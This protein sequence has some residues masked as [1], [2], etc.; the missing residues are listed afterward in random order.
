Q[1]TQI[2][3]NEGNIL[4]AMSAIES[5]QFSSISAAAKAFNILKATL[6]RRVNRGISRECFTPRNKNLT[7][8]EEEVLVREILKLDS[9]G[10]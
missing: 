7:Q 10:L 8:A 6:T 9:Q 3:S 2:S 4:L 5:H 1:R